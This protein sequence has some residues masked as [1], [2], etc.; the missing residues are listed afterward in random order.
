MNGCQER[1]RGDVMSDEDEEQGRL[2]F[3]DWLE[4]ILIIIVIT[5]ALHSLGFFN[6]MYNYMA[7]KAEFD[8]CLKNE[9]AY[10]TPR[11][12]KYTH[13]YCVTY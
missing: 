10:C 9:T 2:I 3:V 11:C 7:Q 8:P 1:C 6:Y 4:I 13:G 5:L 12:S